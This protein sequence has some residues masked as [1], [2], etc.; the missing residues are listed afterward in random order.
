MRL[1]LRKYNFTTKHSQSNLKEVADDLPRIQT[2]ERNYV[3]TISKVK[4]QRT[5]D[6]S[7]S[8]ASLADDVG[9]RVIADVE[10]NDRKL[11]SSKI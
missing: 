1:K 5:V 8:S 3:V 6:E 9:K 4:D 2:S 7:N 11:R 10:T